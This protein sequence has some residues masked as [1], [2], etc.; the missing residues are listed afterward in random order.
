[1][2]CYRHRAIKSPPLDSSKTFLTQPP[3]DLPAAHPGPRLLASGKAVV[4]TA[5][6]TGSW[7]QI[8]APVLSVSGGIGSV[9]LNC[10]WP[11]S[12]ESADMGGAD[13]QQGSVQLLLG[14]GGASCQGPGL[15]F[16]AGLAL[17]GQVTSSVPPVPV[18]ALCTVTRAVITTVCVRW[19]EKT[20]V[21]L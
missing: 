7:P 18:N 14:L 15:C 20:P 1:M 8:P 11:G 2:S 16:A 4:I 9:T 3:K 5:P 13:R 12:K 19:S 21:V 17:L 10:G 6:N